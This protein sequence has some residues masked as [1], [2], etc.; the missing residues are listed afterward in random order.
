MLFSV[1]GNHSKATAETG[2]FR[3]VFT[4]FD[5]V[6]KFYEEFLY[7]AIGHSISRHA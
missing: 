5:N 2:F 4:T 3:S 7:A 6:V 1:N